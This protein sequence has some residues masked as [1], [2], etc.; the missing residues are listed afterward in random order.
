MMGFK[1]SYNCSKI[2]YFIVLIKQ[3]TRHFILMADVTIKNVGLLKTVVAG[4]SATCWRFAVD[5]SVV[6]PANLQQIH[7]IWF[8]PRC[9]DN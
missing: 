6:S 4:M 1:S 9:I 8:D 2:K 7:L 5:K 3:R